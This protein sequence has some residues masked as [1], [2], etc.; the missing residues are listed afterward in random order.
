MPEYLQ[1]TIDKFTFRVA[2]DRYYSSDGVWILPMESAK[3]Q[4]VRLGVTDFFQQHNGDVA[5]A[6]IKSVGSR[7]QTGEEFGELETMKVDVGLPSPVTG[8]IVELNKA[9]ERTPELVNEG[10]YDKGWLAVMEVKDWDGDRAKL[11]DAHAYFTVMQSQA[12]QELS[13]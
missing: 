12:E 3:P 5:F 2:K 8:T 10:P 13:T 6:R 11:L 1:I 9:L 4:H 7:V